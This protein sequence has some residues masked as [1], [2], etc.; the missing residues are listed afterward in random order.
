MGS[1]AIGVYHIHR[2]RPLL[3]DWG[4]GA[5]WGCLGT[6]QA[7]HPPTQADPLTHPPRPLPTPPV[8]GV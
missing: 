6:G 3:S 1:S 7:T 5:F 2:N 4:G 8:G